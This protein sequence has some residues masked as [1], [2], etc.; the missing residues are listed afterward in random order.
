[1]SAMLR[2]AYNRVTRM[3]ER[4]SMM[5]VRADH[6]DGRRDGSDEAAP[7]SVHSSRAA[8]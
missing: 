3:S 1:M 2:A 6:L 5:Q 7:M 8:G 4:K